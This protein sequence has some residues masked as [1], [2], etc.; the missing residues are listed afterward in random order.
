MVLS[1]SGGGSVGYSGVSTAETGRKKGRAAGISPGSRG[2]IK[3]HVSL[4]PP[5]P[6]NFVPRPN[7]A[8]SMAINIPFEKRACQRL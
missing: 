8:N 6:I 5:I 1:W 7:Q 3:L 2:L 4:F